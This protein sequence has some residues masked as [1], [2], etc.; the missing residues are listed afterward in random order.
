[1]SKRVVQI[2]TLLTEP[3]TWAKKQ[4]VYNKGIHAAAK[5][6]MALYEVDFYLKEQDRE[7]IRD[8]IH[9][10][11]ISL[12]NINKLNEYMSTFNDWNGY[13]EKKD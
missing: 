12:H 2:R 3:Q 9:N 7:D 1:M 8:A 6:Q 11:Y 10:Y 4:L 5:V 13:I